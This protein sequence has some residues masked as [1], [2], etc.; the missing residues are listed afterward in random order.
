MLN[1]IIQFS[2][3][4]RIL[5]L[6]ITIF[7]LIGGTIVT[8][9]SE[10][11]VFPDLNAP[12]VTVMT[13]A[14]GY[15]PE[16]VEKAVTFPIETVLNGATNVR[17]VRSTSTSGFSIVWVEFDWGTDIYKARQIVTEKLS[18]LESNFPN[19][20]K[21]PVLGPQS[22]IL[23]EMLIVCLTSDKTS[24]QDLRTIA[25][26]TIRPR[27]LAE[28][29]VA[30]VQVI[31]GDIK[32]YQILL[33][34]AQMK[35]FNVSMDEVRSATN[36]I[37]NNVGGGVLYEYGNEYIIK[38]D[39]NTTKLEDLANTVIRSNEN[40][41]IL[42]SDIATVTIGA[43]TPK[44]GL[45][46][47][48]AEPAVLLT[49]TK[50][51]E[52]DTKALTNS[53]L[54]SLDELK[55][56]L[57]SDIIISTDTFR[58]SNFIDSSISNIKSSLIEGALFVVVVLFFFLMNA[59]TTIISLI[60]LPLSVIVTIIVLHL[61]GYTLNTMSLGGIAIAIGSLVD[62]AI[63]DVENVFKR[64]KENKLLPKEQQQPTSTVVFHASAEVRMPILNST[65]IIIAC[66]LPLFFLTGLEGRLLIPLGISFIVSL[67]AST[68]V[69]LTVTPVLCSFLLKGSKDKELKDPFVTQKIK[70]LYKKALVFSFN[71]KKS[72]L[73]ITSLVFV[74]SLI[75]FFTLGRSFLPSFNEG[76][77]TINVNLMPGI[78]LEESDKI[79]REAEKI[80][81]SIPE[82]K[83]VSRKT[84]RAELAEHSFGVNVSEIEAPYEISNR[85]KSEILKELREKLAVLPGANIEIGQPISHRIDAML[86]GSKAQ[87]AIKL[88][89]PDLN[90]LYKTGSE[91]KNIISTIP[92]I[93]DTNIEQQVARPQ[94]QIKPKRDLLAKYGITMAEFSEFLDITLAGI[95]VS[96]VYE[97]GLPYDITLQL[98]I[99]DRNSIEKIK[100]FMIDSN[101]GKI[102]FS[103]IAEIK[104][105][106]GPN[107][108][109]RENVSRRILISC[110]VSDRD[111][112]GA[113]NDIQDKINDQIT[114]P[115]G[116][117][118]VYG[119]QFE[120]EANASKTLALMSLIAFIIIIMLL[121]QEF[122]NIKQSLIVM[123][124][125]PLAMIGGVIILKL[126]SNELNIPAIIGFIS[127]LG[128]TTRN[129]MLLMSHYN[130]LKAEGYNL[131]D[132]IFKGSVD[133][134]LPIIMTALTSALALIPIALKSSEP[135]N[136]I[137]SPMAIVILGGLI[138]STILNVF[139]VP[140]IYY[141]TYRKEELN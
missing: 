95:V 69:A 109:S 132:R 116:Y 66:F 100:N 92:G 29:G 102:P 76:S 33:D 68:I 113:V 9:N 65:L 7:L 38:G 50:Q 108:I 98:D 91:I 61:L 30:E 128:I 118:L 64:I 2:L 139:I 52:T 140:I 77:F 82:V 21:A 5:V 101:V 99:N 51:P 32:E 37:N 45:A 71:Y 40:E 10:V 75:L 44:L 12:T 84:G 103:Y 83:C 70:Q 130:Q 55:M 87:I 20:V 47:R 123:I 31:G 62:D 117:Y 85:S 53:I 16:E 24:Q 86:S 106:D 39:I 135:G 125:M 131:K 1:K 94:L 6:L 35:Y 107:S 119:G 124:N 74:I 11:D 114:L 59:R 111:L 19:G 126:G 54:K 67:I 137:Q 25:D 26:R 136:E 22:S 97:D 88:F 34:L 28:G 79:G 4:N 115:E 41:T 17:R 58:Q 63:V 23:G 43:K 15:A 105:A 73:T 127:L 42:L 14:N 110:N 36:N 120:N 8:I 60:A 81:M 13:E 46:S 3:N 27:I 112:R 90:E 48:N 141:F 49:I 134:L 57:P 122:K 56:S 80:I 133:R 129:G 93:V 89:G 138:T 72:I 96:Q 78:S 121:Y 104:S 18:T